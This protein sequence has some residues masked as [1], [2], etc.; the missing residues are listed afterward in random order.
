MSGFANVRTEWV[1]GDL[2]VYDKDGLEI[3]HIDGTNR[4][5]VIPSGSALD[6]ASL[7]LDTTELG[8]LDG[9]TAGSL[10]A[11]KVVTRTA[12][13][14]VPLATA[15][16]AAVGANQGN[17]A[18][19]TKDVNLITGADNTTC[20]VLPAAVVGEVI[21]VVNTVANKTLPVF[22]ATGGNI[23]GLGANAAFTMGPARLATFICTAAN[24]WYVELAAAATANVTEQDALTALA[25]ARLI[26][27]SAANVATPVDVTGDVT[28]SDAGVTAIGDGKV[29][30][31][32]LASGAGVGALLT[33]GLGGAVSVL[34][35]SAATDTVIAAHGSKDRACLVLVVVDE[36]YDVGTGTLPTVKVGEA[37]T[38]EKAMAGTVLDTEAAGTVLA[39]AFMNTATKAIIVTTTAA[40]GDATG[41]CSVTVLAIPT[42]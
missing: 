6:V 22:P 25:A 10:T 4:K 35:T 2:Y 18:A 28:I 30:N 39:F 32:M 38:I 20:V 29:T 19:L 31:A 42:T 1:D 37:D 3:F 16:V 8:L 13:Q 34:K 26:V 7:G 33:A 12:A 11:S 40:I 23:N 36:T 9:A 5:L 41:G 14:G 21:R 15:V 17:G 27:G 24:V